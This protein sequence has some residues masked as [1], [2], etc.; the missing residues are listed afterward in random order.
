MSTE[1]PLATI[2]KILH[3][4]PRGLSIEEISRKVPINRISAAKYLASLVHS[5]QAEVK[6]YGRAKIFTATK[7][8]PV[9]QMLELLPS[10]IVIIDEEGIVQDLN[11]KFLELTQMKREDLIENTIRFTQFYKDA[12]EEFEE[13]ILKALSGTSYEFE[14]EIF[15]NGDKFPYK[16]RCLSIVFPN[17]RPGAIILFEENKNPVQI[18]PEYSLDTVI[19]TSEEI[20]SSGS[21]FFSNGNRALTNHS[22][23]DYN[24][25]NLLSDHFN[26]GPPLNELFKSSRRFLWTLDKQ[27]N[28]QSVSENT[29]ELIGY[30]SEELLGRSLLDLIL[31]DDRLRIEPIFEELI[32]DHESFLLIDMKIVHKNGEMINLETS[33]TVIS[34]DFGNF[35]GFRGVCR[36]V[37][38]KGEVT[39]HLLLQRDLGILLGAVSDLDQAL[40]LSIQ[41]AIRA[42]G[43][44]CGCVYL[45]D[46]ATWDLNLVFSSGF[47]E[48]KQKELSHFSSETRQ[49]R[50]VRDGYPYYSK[51]KG[52]EKEIIGLKEEDILS[53][54]IIPLLHEGWV[55]GTF[56]MASHSIE[57]IPRESR[58]ALESIASQ[59]THIII[60]IR[61]ESALKESE[62]RYRTI[63]RTARDA[64]YIQDKN[65]RFID[66]NEATERLLGIPLSLI[67]HRD[68]LTVYGHPIGEEMKAID[69]RVLEGEVIE[70]E[71][72]FIINKIP[73][74]LHFTKVPLRDSDGIIQGLIGISR[75]ITERKL[76]EDA[77]KQANKRLN[78]LAQVTR[79]DINNELTRLLGYITV[80]GESVS[81]PFLLDLVKKEKDSALVIQRQITFTRDYQNIGVRSPEWQDLTVTIRRASEIADLEEISLIVD[82]Q[83]VSIFG[84]PLLEKVFYNLID[85]SIR[86]S[87]GATKIQF[88]I[89]TNEDNLVIL[90]E[91][92]GEGIPDKE[93]NRIFDSGHGKNTG[94][95]LF[96][97]REILS[98]TGMTIHETGIYKKGCRFEITVPQNSYRIIPNSE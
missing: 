41:A 85:N 36:E 91:D 94:F 44:D 3:A 71:R 98:I 30:E 4:H 50:L 57:A 68:V 19:E 2:Q 7:R 49:A 69:E 52:W 77:L 96:L 24:K 9:T 60:R 84:D 16:I 70:G 42:S 93:K 40:S 89:E 78:L 92:D 58:L 46:P 26:N 20:I 65:L 37:S 34:D 72:T 81:D 35:I 90:C 73:K 67:I 59:I 76:T 66:A 11:S 63:F 25:W 54:A 75:D 43:M 88:R 15:N 51:A 33:A 45:M 48:E 55:I 38:E 32:D 80:V 14:I 23:E 95:G 1:G 10:A 21:K 39:S 31:P 56:L 97:T 12:A 86:H 82:C 5:G 29:G 27:G 83:N 8:L 87:K 28:F 6:N 22:I 47:K 17:S 61:I 74:V 64:I 18:Q 79:H 13:G 62:E 53:I